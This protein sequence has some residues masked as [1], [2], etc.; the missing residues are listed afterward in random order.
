MTRDQLLQ[1]MLNQMEREGIGK[2]QYARKYGLSYPHLTRVFNGKA[3]PGPSFLKKIGLE[4]TM[5]KA[6]M[7]VYSEAK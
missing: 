1:Y 5:D 3:N 7:Y 4:R 6:A 2:R